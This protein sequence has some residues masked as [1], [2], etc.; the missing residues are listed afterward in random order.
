MPEGSSAATAIGQ[1]GGAAGEVDDHGTYQEDDPV[2][3]ETLTFPREVTAYG[4][5]LLN[6][7]R[8]PCFAGACGD[9]RRTRH[10]PRGRLK[11]RGTGAEAE[12]RQGVL[13][14]HMSDDGGERQAIGPTRAKARSRETRGEKRL[15]SGW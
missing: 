7:R 15:W 6:L 1:G 13:G 4:E 3:W 14:P 10:P 5:P 8:P 11:A 2:T 9:R 12:G